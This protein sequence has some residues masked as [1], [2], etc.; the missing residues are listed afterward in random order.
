[1]PPASAPDRSGGDE[2]IDAVERERHPLRAHH[3]Q[4]RHRGDAIRQKAV[5]ETGDERRALVA[6]QIA[7]QQVGAEPRERERRNEQQVVAEDDVAGQPVDRQD[8]QRLPEQVLGQRE[9]QRIR[10]KDVGVPELGPAD[11][12]GQQPR[13]VL[14]APAE[15]PHVEQRVAKVAGD[16]TADAED[17]RPGE[18]HGEHGV[19]Q[20]RLSA[21]RTRR[22]RIK[23]DLSR[24]DRAPRTAPG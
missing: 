4:V 18:D 10:M 15:D 9:R 7:H 22:R 6:G 21:P 12:A 17:E 14:G 3:L 23:P 24:R 16:V 1:M 8:L 19:E 13:H 5:D 20:R 2:A 11:G